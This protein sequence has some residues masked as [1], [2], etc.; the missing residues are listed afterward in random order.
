MGGGVSVSPEFSDVVEDGYVTGS[1]SVGLTQVEAKVGGSRQVGREM[2][3]IENAGT[4]V[5]YYGPS[6][7]TTANGAKIEKKQFV[8]L[9][10]GNMAVY[11][12]GDGA[13]GT[14]IVQEFA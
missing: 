6:G 10:V 11:I 4:T 3:Y 7:V 2:I 14:A 8:F 12:I 1:V 5:L 9:P 13:S